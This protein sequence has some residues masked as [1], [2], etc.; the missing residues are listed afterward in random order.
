[1]FSQ[2]D[3]TYSIDLLR[4]IQSPAA[5]LIGL[6]NTDISKPSDPSSFIV[7]LRQAS[8][9]FTQVP[10]NYAVDFAPAWLFS[11]EKIDH[12]ISASN[13]LKENIWQ[14]MVLSVAINNDAIREDMTTMSS[15]SALGLGIRVSLSRGKISDKSKAQAGRIY[16]LVSSL[17]SNVSNDVSAALAKDTTY[18][19]ALKRITAGNISNLEKDTS[20]IR[21]IQNRELAIAYSK[22]DSENS[23]I[24]RLA[25]NLSL[26]RTGFKLDLNA[27]L[28]YNFRDAAFG[29]REFDQ[30]AIWLTGSYDIE[31]SP[32][33]VLGILRYLDNPGE[34]IPIDQNVV[35]EDL[36]IFNAGLRLIYEYDKFRASAELIVQESSSDLLESGAKYVFNLDYQIRNNMSLTLSFGRDFDGTL[37]QE[38]NLISAINF[39]AGFGNRRKVG[40]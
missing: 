25:D 14:S 7:N 35:M 30:A 40:S 2:L 21:L 15:N 37:A 27:A 3:S 39:I 36:R 18:N 23:N 13:G 1:M 22:L 5:T 8:S 11:A 29:N 32:F 4:E 19:N 6:S 10:V 17:N 12:T 26:E 28:S 33:T 24:Q 34:L 38:G 31:K 20:N 16:S 9:D